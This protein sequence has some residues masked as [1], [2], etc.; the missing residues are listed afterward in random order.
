MTHKAYKLLKEVVYFAPLDTDEVHY[1]ADSAL[2]KSYQ[3][4]ES[5]FWE[6]EPSQGLWLIDHGRVKIYKLSA[7]GNEH[8]IHILGDHNT[9]NDIA[10]LDGGANPANASALSPVQVFLIPSEALHV[11]MHQNSNLAIHITRLLA[12]RVRRMVQ[13]MEDLTLYSVVAR[14]ARFLI[15]QTQD[16]ALSGPGVTRMTIASYLNTTP[17]TISNALNS[18]AEANAIS[19]D[20][21]QINIVDER[22]L[23]TIA[24]LE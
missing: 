17:Q 19:F 9:F 15:T 4:G 2:L 23:R 22:V 6:G 12:T 14:L 7:G 8:V 21:H 20:R 24:E 11:M 3:A 18:L 1:L 16:P 5:I 13:Q 10:F